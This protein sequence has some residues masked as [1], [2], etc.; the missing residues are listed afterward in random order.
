M[1][2]HIFVTNFNGVI[3][4]LFKTSPKFLKYLKSFPDPYNPSQKAA[5]SKRPFK[6][7]T[8]RKKAQ[9]QICLDS[10]LKQLPN[11]MIEVL[12]PQHDKLSP[13]SK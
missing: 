12:R 10:I 6:S 3:N 7:W 11:H 4:T 2:N 1:F 9:W 5:I 8:M 13:I